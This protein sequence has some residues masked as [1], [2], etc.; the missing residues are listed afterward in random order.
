MA[1]TKEEIKSL[2]NQLAEQIKHLSPE[3]RKEAQAQIDSMSDSS[4]ESMLRQQQATEVFRMIASKQIDSVIVDEN[5]DA[6]AVLEIKP[7]SEG[8]TLIVP[9]SPVKDKKKIPESI[10]KFA[11][12]ISEKLKSSLKPKDIKQFAE[13]KFGEV[14]ID[15]IPEYDQPLSLE[16]ERKE[17]SKENLKEVLKKINVIKIEKKI[18]KIQIEKP[19]EEVFKLKRRVP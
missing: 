18:E 12:K 3:K 17:S 4:L 11:A 6:L 1:L 10:G 16:S 2:K 19:A 14:I 7:I 15:L 5:S 13:F 9:K 8:H